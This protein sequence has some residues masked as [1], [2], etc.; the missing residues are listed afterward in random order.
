MSNETL[1][2][3][4]PSTVDEGELLDEL[5]VAP[6]STRSVLATK[7]IAALLLVAVGAVGGLWWSGRDSGT[8]AGGFP[9][10]ASGQLPGGFPSGI[11]GA[12]GAQDGTGTTGTS[13]STGTATTGSTGPVVVGT[14]VSVDGDVVVVK[15]LGGTEHEVRT[16]TTTKVTASA[17]V[18]LKDLEPGAT[19][20]VNGTKKDDGSVDA[21]AVTSR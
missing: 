3:T 5:H 10:L 2:H 20:T 9:G 1:L 16:T 11:P 6:P 4:P 18:P 14:V 13:G 19:V 21:T 7:V 15:D 8:A 17:T 12:A